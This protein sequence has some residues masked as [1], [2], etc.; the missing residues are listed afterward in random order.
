MFSICFSLTLFGYFFITHSIQQSPLYILLMIYLIILC[1]KIDQW[2]WTKF[3][4]ITFIVGSLTNF[5]DFFTVPTITLVIP[6]LLYVL[7]YCLNHSIKQSTLF[8]KILNLCILWSLGFAF[9]WASKWAVCDLVLD[10][11][12]IKNALNQILFRSIGAPRQTL[13][14]LM[15]LIK[16]LSLAFSVTIIFVFIYDYIIHKK[17]KIKKTL[18]T[19][20]HS[21]ITQNNKMVI[22]FICLVPIAWSLVTFNHFYNHVIF[23]YRDLMMLYLFVLLSFFE[24]EKDGKI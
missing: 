16:H 21:Y 4:Y 18:S 13:N 2:D 22:L 24:K 1:K 3:Y 8:C 7:Y 20:H 12:I 17:S 19:S 11:S 15:Y 23:T 10:T 14:N 9:T 6:V 5:F